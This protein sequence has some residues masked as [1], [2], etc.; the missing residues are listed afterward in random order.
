MHVKAE[1]LPTLSDEHVVINAYDA[2]GWIRNYLDK[3]DRQPLSLRFAAAPYDNEAHLVIGIRNQGRGIDLLVPAQ[4]CDA[5]VLAPV[6]LLVIGD[7]EDP[8]LRVSIDFD[9]DAFS[10]FVEHVG[11]MDKELPHH[12]VWGALA[13]VFVDD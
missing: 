6:G 13:S 3:E 10:V 1:M 2:K 9:E 4:Q 8:T 7:K 12:E 5:L 11:E